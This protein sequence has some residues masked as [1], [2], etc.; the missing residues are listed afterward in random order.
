MIWLFV[1]L[2]GGLGASLRFIADTAISRRLG[3]HIP[4]GTMIVN[5]LGAFLGGILLGYSH[6]GTTHANL[7]ALL[8]SGLMGGFTTASTLAAEFAGMADQGRYRDAVAMPIAMALVAIVL[9]L[10]G[11]LLGLAL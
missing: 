5:Q 3:R 7:S 2:L 10:L 6:W 4:W 11:L 1:A 9:A 8:L